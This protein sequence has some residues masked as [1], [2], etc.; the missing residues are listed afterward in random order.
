M[1]R[2]TLDTEQTPELTGTDA[3][4]EEAEFGSAGNGADP[5][6]ADLAGTSAEQRALEPE[7]NAPDIR[8]DRVERHPEVPGEEGAPPAPTAQPTEW[9]D[10][11]ASRLP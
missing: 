7:P 4:A 9:P 8:P 11:D 1:A 2:R 5:F 6:E 3:P 10:V